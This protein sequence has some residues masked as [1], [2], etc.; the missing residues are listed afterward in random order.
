M[1][2]TFGEYYDE[3]YAWAEKYNTS[4][5]IFM[6]MWLEIDSGVSWEQARA[7]ELSD[8]LAR[9]FV[10]DMRIYFQEQLNS[11]GTESLYYSLKQEGYSFLMA[12]HSIAEKMGLNMDISEFDQSLTIS[13]LLIAAGL[14]GP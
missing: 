1:P 13:D 14:A 7:M 10:C 11:T 6:E 4:G 2:I 8:G 9:A 5:A 12:A 3:V